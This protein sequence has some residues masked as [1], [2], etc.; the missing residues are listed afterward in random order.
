[1]LNRDWYLQIKSLAFV[2]AG[3]AFLTL[4]SWHARDRL[5][6]QI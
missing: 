2:F 4:V 1:M 3:E 6:A 5:S